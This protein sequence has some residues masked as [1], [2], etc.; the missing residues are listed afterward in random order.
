MRKDKLYGGNLLTEGGLS[1]IASI[2]VTRLVFV[3]FP[4]S[5]TR[6]LVLLIFTI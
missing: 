6:V 4:A 1:G 2:L 5:F 3:S